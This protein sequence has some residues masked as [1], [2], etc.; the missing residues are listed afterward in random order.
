VIHLAIFDTINFE[1]KSMLDTNWIV[2]TGQI[3]IEVISFDTKEALLT[4]WKTAFKPFSLVFAF[5]VDF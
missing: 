4:A 3:I 1:F 5:N 2:R